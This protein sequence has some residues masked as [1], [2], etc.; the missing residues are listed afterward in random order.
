MDNERSRLHRYGGHLALLIIAVLLFVAVR[1]LPLSELLDFNMDAENNPS[2]SPENEHQSLVIFDNSQYLSSS[3]VNMDTVPLLVSHSLSPKLNPVTF[4]GKLPS[5]ELITYTVQALDTPIGIAE[6][7]GISPETILGGNPRLSEE[8][9]SLQTGTV[10][11][12]LPIDGVL[13][14]VQPGETLERIANLYGVTPEDIINYAPN[15]L[16]FPFRL[17]S[18]TQLMVPG[19]VREVFIWSA[20]APQTRSSGSSSA[21]SSVELVATG[22]G[23]FLWPVANR[24]ITQHYWYGHP[25]IDIGS[26]E[27]M[28]VIASDTGTVTWAGW[29]I[30]GYGNLIV[31]NHGN[32][33]ETYYGHLSQV[34]V[35]VGQPVYQGSVIGASGNT[36]RSSGPHLHFEIRYFNTLLEPLAILR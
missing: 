32:G 31:I 20:P 1:S 16:E 9:S 36:G 24:R 34:N 5:H 11:I 6:Q 4:Q 30:Y 22:T 14:D 27:G 26:P 29:N 2:E 28:A 7:F 25:A 33:Y 15:N 12:V 18:N 3:S 19:A 17:Y 13:H 8:A 10:L 35:Q 23:T 21:G